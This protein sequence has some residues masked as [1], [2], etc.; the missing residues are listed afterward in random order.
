MNMIQIG[1]TIVL[2]DHEG[3][4]LNAD[5]AMVLLPTYLTSLEIVYK[6]L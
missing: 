1:K 3:L 6:S 5:S 4:E 2:K